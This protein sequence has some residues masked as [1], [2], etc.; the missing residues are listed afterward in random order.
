[1]PQRLRT[2]TLS[3]AEGPRARR[4]LAAVSFAE[5][6]F[7]PVPPDLLLFPMT[8]RAPHQAWSL[9]ALA[10]IASV[11]GGL[12]GYLLGY[13]FLESVGIHII[14]FY[15]LEESFARFDALYETYGLWILLAAG[16]TPIPY[17]IFTIA[18][19]V[20]ALNLP[21]F[22]A[23]GLLGRGARFFL[24]CWL[25]RIFGVPIRPFLEKQLGWLS[26]GIILFALALLL[27]ARPLLHWAT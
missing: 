22:I 19:G 1:M 18:S 16:F 6:S 25:T 9:A 13:A 5:S 10:T 27:L 20:A 4:A 24:V 15:A 21:I 11:A 7:F 8:L 23:A 26:L 14:A 2:W 3:L 17:K 12:F